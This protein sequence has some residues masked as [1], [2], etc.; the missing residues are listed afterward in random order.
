M[1]WCYLICQWTNR[2]IVHWFLLGLNPVFHKRFFQLM[3]LSLL[4]INNLKA[5][6]AP[7]LKNLKSLTGTWIG[8]FGST[9]QIGDVL[10]EEKEIYPILVWVWNDSVIKKL[11]PFTHILFYFVYWYKCKIQILSRVYYVIFNWHYQLGGMQ[12]YFERKRCVSSF[13]MYRNSCIYL[14]HGKP[15]LNRTAINIGG[16]SVW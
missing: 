1:V 7:F 13:L 9:K 3:P 16:G 14:N 11:F 8:W 10:I 5:D 6:V 12:T 2:L 4:S 15:W